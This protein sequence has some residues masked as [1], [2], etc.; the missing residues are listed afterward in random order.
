MGSLDGRVAVVTGAGGG[1]GAA[2]AT[3]LARAGASVLVADIVA[4]KAETTCGEIAEAGGRARW[5]NVDVAE[6][7]QVA[8]MID[9]AVSV[10]GRIDILHNN[11]AATGAST[12]DHDLLEMDP[13]VWDLTMSVNLRGPMLGAKH[14]IPK[15][16][17]NGSGVII[18]TSSGAGLLAEPTR[19]AYGASKAGLNSLTRYIAVR[20]GKQ[21]IRAVAV[22]PG[23]TLG[24]PARDALESTEWLAMMRRHHLLPDLG[25]PEDIGHLVAFLASDEARFITGTVIS[26]DGGI[27][28]PVPYAAEMLQHGT[29][30]F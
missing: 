17:N 6:E 7:A 24:Q 22:A 26:I 18:N 5:L 12:G 30:L 1:I 19:P 23:I 10:F 8:E 20:Y 29:Q 11:A 2:C 9:Y 4:E 13:S 21:G 25:W 16:I 27:V 3:E 28:A 15:M 14:A